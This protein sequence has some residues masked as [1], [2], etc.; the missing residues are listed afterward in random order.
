MKETVPVVTEGQLEIA[1]F[2]GKE[3]RK[4]LHD[5]EWYFSVVD[6]VEAVMET[7][8]PSRYWNELKARLVNGEGY[9]ELFD[10]IEK[11][12]RL[13]MKKERLVSILTPSPL[14]VRSMAHPY[15]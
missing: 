8:S 6:V 11:F 5:D 4:V 1:E 12:C 9:D 7:A 3:I 10:K 14:G 15:A 2:K 13:Y